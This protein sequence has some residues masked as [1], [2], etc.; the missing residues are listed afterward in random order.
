MT[1]RFA[2]PAFVLS[3]IYQAESEGLIDH[4]QYVQSILAFHQARAEDK[5]FS[6]P[7]FW[8][9]K[10]W[11]YEEQVAPF[12]GVV[13]VADEPLTLSQKQSPDATTLVTI[14]AHHLLETFRQ[15]LPVFDEGHVSFSG[16]IPKH[17]GHTIDSTQQ[18]EAPSSLLLRTTLV[19]EERYVERAQL[20]DGALGVVS[21]VGDTSMRRQVARKV[22]KVGA[23]A[24]Q[25]ERAGI[26]QEARL[27]GQLEHPN[28]VPVYDIGEL[29]DGQIYYTMRLLP[30]KTLDHLIYNETYTLVEAVQVVQQICMG[31]EY[32][33]SRGVVHCDIKPSNVALGQFGEVLILDWGIASVLDPS[34]TLAACLLVSNTSSVK[35][36]PA[37]MAPELIAEERLSAAVDQYAL[38]VILYELLTRRLPFHSPHIFRL[39]A[40]IVSEPVIPP[41]ERAS[42]HFGIPEELEAI[43]LKMLS[44]RPE[45]RFSSCRE[46][47]KSLGA[48]LEGRKEQQRREQ[49]AGQRIAEA[50]GIRESYRT[51]RL[52]N[53]AREVALQEEERQTETWLPLS[54]KAHLLSL[55]AHHKREMLRE[56]S[57]FRGAISTYE[58][59]LKFFPEH[60]EARRGLAALYWDKFLEME[61]QED[62]YQQLYYKESLLAYDDGTY[63]AML[64][65]D[66]RLILEAEPSADVV[67]L[68]Y[69]EES[70]RQIP[71]GPKYLG[72]T[73]LDVSLPPG[74]YLLQLKQEGYRDTPYPVCLQREGTWRGRVRLYTEEEISSSYV[75][76]PGGPF[77]YGGDPQVLMSQPATTIELGD[78]FISRFPVTFGDYLLFLNE[79]HQEH[80]GLAQKYRPG[81]KNEDYV[82]QNAQG[83][84]EVSYEAIFAGAISKRYPEGEGFEQQV[85][86]MGI[87]LEAAIAYARWLSEHDGLCYALPTEEQWV[88]AARGADRRPFPW[89]WHFEPSFCKMGLSRPAD[90]LQPEP[91]GV[92]PYDCSPYG[93]QDVVGTIAEWVWPSDVPQGEVE[94]TRLGDYVEGAYFR[95]GGW[96]TH[97]SNQMRIGTRLFRGV[98][99]PSYNIGFRLVKLPL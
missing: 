10:K 75:Y 57:L 96:V 39:L 99:A 98:R 88:K 35:G 62:E 92:F 21:E 52:A 3:V 60:A 16:L 97:R 82:W 51:C 81:S 5:V 30:S 1:A 89:G 68:T 31:L 84:F 73:P 8:A 2:D 37:Y 43:C 65:G 33:H 19:P 69:K 83:L 4:D 40:D 12:L 44:K 27:T 79:L 63:E 56:V 58:Q 54:E 6:P 74:S 45:Q 7:A 85:P 46:V 61:A 49:E 24:S 55:R 18:V 11:L 87:S 86:V 13:E 9:E 25:V 15:Q 77:T 53:Q 34:E 67:L 17:Q 47:Y 32:A 29:E 28:I 64:E 26:I 50:D 42:G 72:Q 93:M 14:N 70:L 80:P 36:T 20:G 76:V 66:C 91:I 59:A 48:F 95:G 38:G 41:R 90:E 71:K 78:F 94:P 22:L 23:A